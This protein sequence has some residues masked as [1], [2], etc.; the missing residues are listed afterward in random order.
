[1]NYTFDDEMLRL[2]SNPLKSKN[3]N[4]KSH[5]DT[6]YRNLSY[7]FKNYYMNN[8][9]FNHIIYIIEK[10]LLEESIKE[11]VEETIETIIKNVINKPL[12]VELFDEIKIDEINNK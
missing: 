2:I 1:M 9:K 8:I 5:D 7:K 3:K 4:K 12:Y 11:L 10:Y 6:L